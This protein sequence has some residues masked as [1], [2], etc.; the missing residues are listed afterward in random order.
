MCIQNVFWVLQK[1]KKL[2]SLP[3]ERLRTSPDKLCAKNFVSKH[4]YETVFVLMNSC[5]QL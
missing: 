4:R 5:I 1:K 2:G 3:D